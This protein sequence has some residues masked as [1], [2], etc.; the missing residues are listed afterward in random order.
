MKGLPRLYVS[1]DGYVMNKYW[2]MIRNPGIRLWNLSSEDR[3]RRVLKGLGF[4]YFLQ[5]IQALPSTGSILLVRG[6]YLFDERILQV[7]GNEQNVIFRVT[8]NNQSIPVAAHVQASL[9]PVVLDALTH[10]QASLLPEECR[11]MGLEDLS[12]GFSKRL[13]KS[14]APYVLPIRSDNQGKLEELLF[15]G[16]YKGVTDL[17]TK[18]LWPVPAKWVTH[19]C[20]NHGIR[21]NH[22]TALSLIMAVAAGVLFFAGH[23]WLGLF[24]G[25]IM[26]FLD[27][28]DG[29]LARVTITS[30]WWGNIFDHGID[31]IHPP[32]WYLAWG[33]GVANFTPDWLGVS[34]E[35]VI[36]V[37]FVG[38]IVGRLVEGFWHLAITGFGI[39]LWRPFDSYFRLV[40][41]RRNPSLIILSVS[42]LLGRPDSGLEIVAAWTVVST[43]I[44]LIRF[45]MGFIEK[46]KVGALKSW[47]AEIDPGKDRGSLS[48]RVFT[49]PPATAE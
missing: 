11:M 44:L 41:A 39:F 12:S 36:T 24:L 45:L 16:S 9:A 7:L 28:V 4:E 27:T 33:M 19:F 6:D 34:L 20:A 32:L 3:L 43:V 31:L 48:V 18:F 29:K 40:T 30:S 35:T 37:I 8:R 38:Y 23:L 1:H 25:W 26:T 13:K 10:K 47:L 46:S 42:L 21:P 22:V 14:N 5:D 2:Y 15:S 49:N 17:V